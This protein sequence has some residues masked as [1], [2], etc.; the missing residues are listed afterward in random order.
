M[1]G[2]EGVGSC[3]MHIL[4]NVCFEVSRKNPVYERSMAKLDQAA[5]SVSCIHACMHI[6]I[7][8]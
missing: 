5:E 3:V 6:Y 2:V 4:G 7:Y 8:I 1:H